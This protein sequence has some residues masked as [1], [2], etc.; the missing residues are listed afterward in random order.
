MVEPEASLE[1][2]IMN[3]KTK[4][5]MNFCHNSHWTIC[6]DFLAEKF[7]IKLEIALPRIHSYLTLSIDRFLFVVDPCL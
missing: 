1:S 2:T 4:E 6:Y 3:L 5:L 7:D